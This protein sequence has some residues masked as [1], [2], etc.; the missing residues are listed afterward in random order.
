M[1]LRL[2]PA[3]LLSSLCFLNVAATAS[4][5]D[6][7]DYPVT[8]RVDQVD[9]YHDEQVA[10]PYRW[11]E[12][13]VRNS[14]EVAAWVAAENE[15]ARAYLDAIEGRE[16]IRER[17]TEL[18]DYERTSLP[19]RQGE[20]YFFA[21]NDGLQNQAVYYV[22]DGLESEPE[23]LLDPNTWSEDGTV[24]L[25]GVSPSEDG[26][27]VAYAIVEAGS[28]WRTW[29]VM[30]TRTREK[31]DDELAWTKTWGVSWTRDNRG[32]FYSRFPQP[33]DEQAYQSINLNE[34]IYYHRIGT[35]Q[36]A[37]VLVFEQPDHPQWN[38]DGTV[39]EDGRYLIITVSKGTDRK[40]R[41]YYRDL[42]DPYAAPVALIDNFDHEYSFLGNDGTRF[43]FRT[44]LDAPRK[45]VDCHPH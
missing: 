15:V 36:S 18:Y 12:E 24:S 10:D 25:G 1:T 23:V 3:L 6:R 13:D 42:A 34:K 35:P 2:R 37:D 11:L 20:L 27:Y 32:F 28:D 9:T 5:A 14:A 21:K 7:L 33:A 38:L 44:D 8:R 41:V 4:D 40:Y 45:R 19:E 43:Y 31:L 16:A 26:E 17:L 39:T 22:Q 30:Q 29:H